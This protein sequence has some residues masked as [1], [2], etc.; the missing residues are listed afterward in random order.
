MQCKYFQNVK[1]NEEWL[2]IVEALKLLRF[3]K[4][5]L[6]LALEH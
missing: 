1:E 4:C 3:L 5:Q 6:Y 2:L